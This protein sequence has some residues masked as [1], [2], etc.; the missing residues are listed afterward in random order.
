MPPGGCQTAA[1][2]QRQRES[3]RGLVRASAHGPAEEEAGWGGGLEEEQGAGG[4]PEGQPGAPERGHT[5][6][7]GAEIL[8][9]SEDLSDG[10][11]EG[12]EHH[13]TQGIVNQDDITTIKN[14]CDNFFNFATGDCGDLER[15]PERTRSG[16]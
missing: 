1:A 3:T 5:D 6:T 9:G 16:V 11:G 8:S 7:G 13:T 4:G 2:A 14:V 12:R 10:E 15:D